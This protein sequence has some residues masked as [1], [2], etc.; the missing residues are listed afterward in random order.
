MTLG[1]LSET[2]MSSM[3]P[4]MLAGPMERKRKLERSGFEEMRESLRQ[5][6][7][8]FL[9]DAEHHS[10][11]GLE[12]SHVLFDHA[13]GHQREY[14][15]LVGSRS[16]GALLKFAHKELT[17][18]VR[19]HLEEA[20]TRHRLTPA[21]PVEIIG[22]YAVSALLALFTWWFDN[23]SPYTSEQMARMF[24]RLT[25]PAVAAGLSLSR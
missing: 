13:A 25:K 2:S 11:E 3:R 14:R 23:G 12:V 9:R 17:S 1:S 16:G 18:L 15:A 7:A 19:E 24:E 10:G 6:L 21:V 4:P 5:R 8:A 20:V 22:Y